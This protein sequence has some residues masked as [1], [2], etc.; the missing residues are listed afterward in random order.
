[1]A[2]IPNVNGPGDDPVVVQPG[3]A[4]KLA[5]ANDGHDGH[6]DDGGFASKKKD[7]DQ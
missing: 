6:E 1:M 4:G 3:G 2:T 5:K 7:E